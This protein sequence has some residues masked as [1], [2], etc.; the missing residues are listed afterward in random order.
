M[1]NDY[2][3]LLGSDSKIT[4]LKITN[5]PYKVNTVLPFNIKAD[6]I[7]YS[8]IE[9]AGDKFLLK[10]GE[11]IGA[12]SELYSNSTRE[13]PIDNTF[14]R[15]Y[16]RTLSVNIPQGY[17]IANAEALDF[18]VEFKH[19]DTTYCFFKSS[20][21]IDNNQLTININE[22]Y[23]QISIPAT[24]YESFR[25]VINAAADFQKVKL[26]FEKLN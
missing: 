8:L 25:A 23:N 10:I 2:I 9:N 21:S 14:N 17:K 6:A 19:A 22:F 13:N 16:V 7:V 26:L 18:D 5:T 15:G 24:D 1:L 12:Q 3:K 4:N 11:C 20:Y